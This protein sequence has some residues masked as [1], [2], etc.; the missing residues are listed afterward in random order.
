MFKK[1]GICSEVEDQQGQCSISLM[2]SSSQG[3]MTDYETLSPDVQPAITSSTCIDEEDKDDS[4]MQFITDDPW[5]SSNVGGGGGG[6]EVSHHVA[7]SS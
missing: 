2:E 3:V 4:W 7:F 5:C 1:N 6:E